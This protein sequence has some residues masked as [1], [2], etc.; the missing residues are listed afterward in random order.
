MN[1]L[2]QS[3]EVCAFRSSNHWK[4]RGVIEWRGVAFWAWRAAVW[5]VGLFLCGLLGAMVGGAF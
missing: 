3:L 2:F 1:R 5:V 4:L